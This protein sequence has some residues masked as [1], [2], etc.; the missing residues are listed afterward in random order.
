MVGGDA[1]GSN[2]GVAPGAQWIA[3]FL[4]V[5][6]PDTRPYKSTGQSIIVAVN[7]PI[8]CIIRQS[9]SAIPTFYQ[10]LYCRKSGNAGYFIKCRCAAMINQDHCVRL[11]VPAFLICLRPPSAFRIK[12]EVVQVQ[13]Q[14]VSPGISVLRIGV[15]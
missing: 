15:L 13:R 5:I 2:I 10:I 9:R 14:K 8:K 11:L 1:G 3:V 7:F 12:L 6:R 4:S